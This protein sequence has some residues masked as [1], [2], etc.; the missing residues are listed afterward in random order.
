[1]CICPGESASLFGERRR[2][3]ISKDSGDRTRCWHGWKGDDCRVLDKGGEGKA[4]YTVLTA[5]PW[6]WE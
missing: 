5:C 3:S 2:R 6:A 4:S 1:M